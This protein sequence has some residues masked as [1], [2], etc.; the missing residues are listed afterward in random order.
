MY[1]KEHLQAIFQGKFNATTWQGVL[2]Q[3]FGAKE[4]RQ[5]PELLDYSTNNETAYYLGKITMTDGLSLGLFRY[6]INKGS[7]VHKRVGLRNLVKT[8]TN[9]RYGIF[10]A[11]LAVFDDG[12]NWRVSFISDIR[13]EA[14]APKRYTF[15]FGDEM[16]YYHTATSRFLKLQGDE[17]SFKTLMDAFS[18]E[19]LSKEFFTNYKQHYDKF[20]NHLL[21]SPSY[22]IALFKA[23]DKA[24][25]DFCK[26]LLGRIVFLY[27]LQKK[28]WLGA[29]DLKY[30]DGDK[31]FMSNLFRKH[32]E[33]SNS[34]GDLFYSQCLTKL[35]FETLNQAREN[36]NFTMP[37]GETVKIPFLNGG[38]F[39]K[40]TD[41]YEFLDFPSCLFTDLF[42]FFDQYNFTIYEDDPNDHTVAVDPEMLGHIFENL[43]EDNK[44]KGAYYTPKEIVHYMCQ[45]S[46]KEYLKTCLNHDS[47]KIN[48]IDKILDCIFSR[49]NLENLTEIKVQ[50]N[51]LQEFHKA[52][53]NVKICDPAIGSG[54]FPMG[55][56]QEIFSAKQMLYH[57]EHGSLEGFKAS[58]VKLNIIQNSIYGVDIERG[59]VDI[60]RLRFWLS[61]IIDEEVPTPLPNL[62][63]KIVVGNS[64]VSKLDDDVIDIDWS[65]DVVSQGLFG[66]DLAREK[67]ELLKRISEKQ[68]SYFSPKSDKKQLASEIRNL[69]IDLL[70]NQLQLMVSTKGNETKPTGTS[71]SVTKQLDTYLQTLGWKQHVTKLQNLKNKPDE[72]LHFFDWKL[73]FPEVM[74]PMLA[75]NGHLNSATTNCHCGLDSDRSEQAPQSQEK[76]VGFDIVIGNPPYVFARNSKSKGMTEQ[77]KAYYYSHY[78]LSEYQINLY[79]LFV[80]LG[81]NLLKRKG[82]FS[83]ITPNNWLTLNTNSKLRRF[84]LENSSISIINFY[85][86]VFES[87]DVDSAVFIFQKNKSNDTREKV[88]L[89]EWEDEYNLVG[90]IEKQ[91]LISSKDCVINIEALKGNE[92]FNLLDKI[93]NNSVSLSEFANVKASLVAYETGAGDPAQTE[94]IKKNRAFHSKIGGEGYTKYLDGCD[95]CRYNLGWSGEY[96]KYGKHLAAPRKNFDLF[97]TPRILVRQ[98]PSPLPYC[99]NACYTEEILLN[100]RNSMNIIYIKV[101]P[102]YLLGILNSK[103]I[104]YW[105]AHKFGKLQRGIFPQFKI[106]ELAQFPIPKL[107]KTEQ[108][109]I[110]A[111]VEQILSVKKENPVADTSA[112]EKEIDILV[113][114]LYGLSYD[115]V[116]II[117]PE[118][119]INEEE[120]NRL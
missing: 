10:D 58:D 76:A 115:E 38:L 47:D 74:N 57:F 21:N 5:T 42:T 31:N 24:I 93:E 69:K 9:P 20:C 116:K 86:R 26:K 80:E 48:E 53:D 63:Y 72:P 56:L 89:A 85:K 41:K 82:I 109:P 71:K 25:R 90:E 36:D 99:I 14:T 6:Q 7:V 12:D 49:G 67:V 37:N 34:G 61:L 97:S 102:K 29:K 78:I 45:E 1:I 110:I 3:L 118:F 87:A 32:T 62:D 30:K 27:F 120:Y 84:V 81:T 104:S 17:I 60:A 98:I 2:I 33:N 96:L 16:Q 107:S 68:K 114:K 64:L 113:Y 79:P 4:L 18:V 103:L 23:N 13:G 11:A 94:E 112:L 46:L 55:L 77:D 19:S 88:L 75:E 92:T 51:M 101:S 95:V 54:A 40:E 50:D 22:R 70:I 66:A 119:E 108:Q 100:D 106:N 117:E 91:K 59:A 8:F 35:F 52:L 39:E 111:F 65:L 28:G 15:V 44:D 83:F 105:F 43:L 73:D